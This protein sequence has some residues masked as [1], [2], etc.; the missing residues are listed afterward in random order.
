MK[1]NL[2]LFLLLAPIFLFA[3][4]TMIRP[5]FAQ[6]W[7]KIDEL[8]AIGNF[9]QTSPLLADIKVM[10]KRN[11]FRDEYIR[12][13]LA[14]TRTLM[15][16]KTKDEAFHFIQQYFEESIQ[17]GDSV[18]RSIVK[19]FYALFLSENRRLFSPVSSNSF[20][21]AT[22]LEKQETIDGLF[23]AS[24]VSR[25]LLQREHTQQWPAL[26]EDSGN[27]AF[28]P[29]IYHLLAYQYL[30]L[31]EQAGQ[32]KRPQYEALK[33]EILTIN[34]QNDFR[35][36]SAF[37]LSDKLVSDSWNIHHHIPELYRIMEKY[38]S[39]YNA[40]ILSKIAKNLMQ[41]GDNKAA[42]SYVDQVLRDYPN[43]SWHAE[44]AKMAK[45][46]KAVTLSV[47]HD[48]T[49]PAQ[50]YHPITMQ[51]RNVDSLYIKVFRTTNSMDLP[52]QHFLVKYDS[53]NQKVQ[54]NAPLLYE[55][56]VALPHFE[57]YANHNSIYK[58]NPLTYGQY[59]LLVSN[60]A[61]FKDD[62]L[63]NEVASSSFT[64]SDVFVTAMC[65]ELDEHN[66]KA[67][68]RVLLV[69]R[70]SGEPYANKRVTLYETS[71]TSKANKIQS[72][73]TSK[74][75]EFMYRTKERKD[76]ENLGNYDLLLPQENQLVSLFDLEIPDYYQ[77]DEDIADELEGE[78]TALTLTDRAIYR[79][80]QQVYFKTILY[81]NSLANGKI[82]AQKR[83][84]VYL[85]DA[86]GQ[87]VDSLQAT[88]NQ[89]G[90]VNGKLQIPSKTL[91]GRFSLQVFVG[92]S[93]MPSTSIQVEEY[94]RPT[95]SVNFETNKETYKLRD[96]A[97]FIGHAKSFAGVPIALANVRYTIQ[98]H[99]QSGKYLRKEVLDTITQTDPEGKF[100]IRIPLT[101]SSMLT[102]ERFSLNYKAEVTSPSGEMQS[103]DGNYVYASKPWNI[104][105]NSDMYVA[106]KN[107]S[108]LVVATR[109]PNN[110]PLPIS[111][112]VHIY[113]IAAPQ[114]VIPDRLTDYFARA[115]YHLLSVDD[116][117]RYF[118]Q[119][120]DEQLLSKEEE[121][122]LIKS[123][124]FDTHQTDTIQLDRDLFSTGKYLIEAIS[125]QDKDT[126][127]ATNYKQVY[128]TVSRRITANTFLTYA[129][130]SSSYA[131][132]DRVT[133]RFETD[134]KDARQLFIFSSRLGMITSTNCVAIKNGKAVYSFIL[135]EAD[136]TAALTW[137]VL[138]IKS[139][140]AEL[141][142]IR[143][144]IKQKN[145][146]LG[147]EALTFRNKIT[148]GKAEQWR[149]KIKQQGQIIPAE[150]AL[151]M[152]DASLDEFAAHHFPSAFERPYR[153]GYRYYS[154][155]L[156]YMENDFY[157]ETRS[158]S[159]Y[160][161][162]LDQPSLVAE[163]PL[164]RTYNLWYSGGRFTSRSYSQALQGKA[165]GLA[166][167]DELS[168]LDEVVVAVRGS[169]S[170]PQATQPLLVVDGE[171][172]SQTD[173]SKIPPE[174]IANMTIL[175][176][177]AATAIYGS[178]GANGVIVVTTK[179]G[180]KA[181]EQLNAVQARKN[182]Q[183]TAFF[184]PALYTDA[185]GDILVEFNSPEAL[186]R[187]KLLLF[188]HSKD[189]DAGM[190]TFFTQTQKELMVSPNMPRYFREND[191]LL[192]KATIQNLS[193]SALSGN[194]RLTFV[195]PMT[196]EDISGRFLDKPTQ[197]FA[198]DQK[199]NL[200][201]SWKI[202]IPTGFPHVQVNI[203]AA[204]ST[205]S[206]G[207]VH[208]LAI[209]P[210]RV[211]V[212]E[213]EPVF[214][215]EN[216]TKAYH[217]NTSKRENLQA[218]IQLHSN[219]IIEVI[220]ALEYLKSYPYECTEQLSSKWFGLK[221]VQYIQKHYPAIAHYFN[222]LQEQ[223]T[224]SKLR[225]NSQLSELTAEEMPWLR[226]IQ[227]DEKRLQALAVL[228][229]KSSAVEI[230]EIEKKLRKQQLENGA[231]PWFDGG[232][233]NTDIS[234]RLLEIW[235][236]V[237]KLDQGLVSKEMRQVALKLTQYLDTT[238][239]V[240]SDQASSTIALDYL[241]SRHYWHV[242]YPL[243]EN[244][245]A[246]LANKI[247][248]SPLLTA[249]QSAGIAAK[250][251]IVNQLFGQGTQAEQIRNR[252]RQE[253]IHDPKKGMYW[254]SNDK[255]YNS[256][257]MQAYLVEAYKLNDPSRLKAITQW[258][259]YAKQ[260]NNWQTTWM[261]V[262][263]VYALLLSN[264]PKDFAMENTV[265]VFIDQQPLPLTAASLGQVAHTFDRQALADNLE[266]TV[267]NANN[268]AIY[269]YI[270]QQY[271]ANANELP[272]A[273]NN[274]SISKDYLVERDGKWITATTAKLGE[275]IKIRL[276]V[277]AADAFSNL[278]LKDSR[279][280][281]VEP[282]Y[283]A[284][285]YRWYPGYY[286]SMK[287]ASTNYFFDRLSKGK[288]VYEYEV[289]ANNVGTFQSGMSTI[290]SMYDPSVH[291]RAAAV[292]LEIIE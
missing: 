289:K 243:A 195:D 270:N 147:I 47:E 166:V 142:T 174:N 82:V 95:F 50:A 183:E 15:V 244:Q 283:Q 267:K 73:T 231:F 269:G 257:S 215:Q 46:I 133:I 192:L 89:F 229:D 280:A 290:G 28:M 249:N 220:G 36:A 196:D 118:P 191:E 176:D 217:L 27:I 7:K 135:K 194:I 178:R 119:Q 219:P 189:L 83:V 226:A 212:S 198:V 48:R 32:D 282:I 74:T 225:E 16:N 92:K 188:A 22:E 96:T 163:L 187:W 104:Q 260:A 149:F 268:R 12:A 57:D 101:D 108:T 111:G 275:K 250:S 199:N 169:A 76:R 138:L 68:F 207:E 69:D 232:R 148:P 223:E 4:Q 132:G 165:L 136:A 153:Y 157:N 144:P 288:H 79:P 43:A 137:D 208:E 152:Y 221:M 131:V 197:Q 230:N 41:R 205:F 80:G 259:Y 172:L 164:P 186:S 62:G 248:Q 91:N 124:R 114:T 120:F 19:N 190:E 184:L 156:N 88:S 127:R 211:L 70:K 216:E 64:V 175:K 123:Y 26:F 285:G 168:S 2:L 52:A 1:R 151:S 281:G 140:M 224:G 59:T 66:D 129:L 40:Y 143:I 65:E 86:N 11:N 55:E 239:N 139:N 274:L 34:D 45:Q 58:I 105:I 42:I 173:L 6:K 5:E 60:N 162:N 87:K 284:S 202:N 209:L 134:L 72:F 158:N 245:Q 122:T 145:R 125:V 265:S 49:I 14:E 291:A 236:K 94:K 286:F 182:L 258:L 161:R 237:W 102:T 160:A 171:I 181:Q 81:N 213:T 90:S 271:F 180:A 98:F 155:S 116:Y 276:T 71:T 150:V 227:S 13:I 264:D 18:Q 23:R 214:L 31:L 233:A 201:V 29:T 67:R 238:S 110:Q 277:I 103:A 252:I 200:T 263:A 77:D 25:D 130:D 8:I 121:K 266:L 85:H 167:G 206:D 39:D 33:R 44:A 75:G 278:H 177:A 37:L 254:E 38:P 84:T 112:E 228:F 246:S 128:D 261:T 117:K 154:A 78:E 159:I 292:Q 20:I 170:V 17:E 242:L 235:G 61:A 30:N 256:V 93:V 126:I 247:S 21:K 107:W 185:N 3:Q 35:A 97:V 272:P 109:N 210:N 51:T 251:W 241:F 222:N 54:L 203:V 53:L 255:R 100:Y 141:K 204:T 99:G 253:A 146:Q 56:T 63:Y 9:E 10:A 113:K 262:D 218:K 24:L 234:I 240:Y 287:D 273:V 279:P 179:I 193:D 115:N 106:E